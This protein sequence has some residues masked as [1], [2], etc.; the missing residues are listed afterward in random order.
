VTVSRDQIRK[1]LFGATDNFSDERIVTETAY[2]QIA[3]AIDSNAD[4]YL[5]Q[6][7]LSAKLRFET[8]DHISKVHPK[9]TVVGLLWGGGLSAD[10]LMARNI[11]RAAKEVGRP[12]VPFQVIK[13]MWRSWELT[14]P[15][16]LVSTGCAI[17]CVFDDRGIFWP[18]G[19]PPPTPRAAKVRAAKVEE[20][21]NY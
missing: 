3:E 19:P 18:C 6:T 13:R 7:N 21:V 2:R 17:V 14:W 16:N 11:E 1:D 8:I 10:D 5:D 15:A 20:G 12:L 4:V 9:A